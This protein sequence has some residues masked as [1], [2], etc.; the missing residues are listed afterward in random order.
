MNL[1]EIKSFHP[2]HGVQVINIERVGAY[3]I[4]T[5]EQEPDRIGLVCIWIDGAYHTT[6]DAESS[7]RFLEFADKYVNKLP[8][9]N[10]K[11]EKKL[12][13]LD[14]KELAIVKNII[15]DNE[16]LK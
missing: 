8:K 3:K 9:A 16:S 12:K 4:G 6:L 2:T 7:K 13:I 15:K 10:N 5:A 11:K 14:N 1:M